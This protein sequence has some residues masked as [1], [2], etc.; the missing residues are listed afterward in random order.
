M[1]A[2]YK[3]ASRRGTA[4]LAV[5]KFSAQ[6]FSC[7]PP[8]EKGKAVGCRLEGAGQQ[9]RRKKLACTTLRSYITLRL[10]APKGRILLAQPAAYCRNNLEIS[11]QDAPDLVSC[12]RSGILFSR[13]DRSIL[14]LFFPR[15]P[16]RD[17]RESGE[18]FGETFV[19]FF[20]FVLPDT[21]SLV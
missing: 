10:L 9:G 21:R 7:Q 20:S 4:T 6:C 2:S 19:K 18:S 5:R 13:N 3:Y 8:K 12:L 1:A 17:L 11:D 16:S 15:D 14:F